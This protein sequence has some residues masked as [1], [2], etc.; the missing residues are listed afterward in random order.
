LT[1]DHFPQYYIDSL[2]QLSLT[3]NTSK[4]DSEINESHE[5][6]EENN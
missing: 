1:N 4:E 6:S 3:K 5:I 2:K